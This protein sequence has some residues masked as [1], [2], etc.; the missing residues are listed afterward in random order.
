MKASRPNDA[1]LVNRNLSFKTCWV[2]VR[3]W[4]IVLP[5]RVRLSWK[6]DSGVNPFSQLGGG[7]RRVVLLPGYGARS[8]TLL[9]SL[10]RLSFE[11]NFEG[12]RFVFV[13]KDFC[14][15]R[16]DQPGPLSIFPIE[17]RNFSPVRRIQKAD[18]VVDIFVT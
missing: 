6:S 16:Q 8:I 5:C 9:I 18:D 7:S 4:V 1:I 13:G 10:R 2:T 15:R 12:C 17:Q 11:D 3:G 14:V